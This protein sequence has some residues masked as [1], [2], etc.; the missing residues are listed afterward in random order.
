MPSLL[1]L[2]ARVLGKEGQVRRNNR[3]AVFSSSHSSGCRCSRPEVFSSIASSHRDYIRHRRY[4]AQVYS[5][6]YDEEE[7]KEQE[8]ESAGMTDSG[9]DK[10][11]L[12]G[13]YKNVFAAQEES[14][15]QNQK[16]TDTIG[17]S[18]EDVQV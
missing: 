17:Y 13:A 12:D 2:D 7:D 16:R 5:D 15:G 18:R 11:A 6:S 10:E 8:A 1:L 14:K 3:T 4:R 9:V